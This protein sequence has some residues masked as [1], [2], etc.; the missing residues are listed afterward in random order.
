MASSHVLRL[1]K[2]KG[3]GKLLAAAKHNRRTIQREL[4]ADNHINASRMSLNYSLAGVE[5]PEAIAAEA[6]AMM[7]AAGIEKQRKDGVTAIEILF[8]LPVSHSLDERAFF[9]DCLAWVRSH[10]ACHVLSFDVHMDESTPHAHALLL[11]LVNGRMLG[12]DMVGNRTRLRALQSIFYAQVGMKH[13]LQK[14][15]ARLSGTAKAS[16][17]RTVLNLLKTDPA[18]RSPVWPCIRDL[19]KLDPAPFAH[20]LGVGVGQP[21]AKRTAVQIMTGKGKGSNPIGFDSS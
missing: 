5:S 1:A 2:L 11:P 18:M 9:A 16:L 15:I 20:L 13:G 10:F 8:S 12:S 6:K 21:R 3:N 4:G 19:I 7:H 17:E 14:P